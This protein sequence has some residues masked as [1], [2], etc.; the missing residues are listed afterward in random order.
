[1]DRLKDILL[2]ALLAM[3]AVTLL[4]KDKRAD[5]DNGT[6][7][8]ADTVRVTVYDTIAYLM[9]TASDSTVI[10]R[11]TARLAVADSYYSGD[12]NYSNNSGYSKADNFPNKGNN[13]E[14]NI[15]DSADVVVPITQ[16]KYEDS[17]YRAWVSGY[18]ASLDTLIFYPRTEIVTITEREKPKRWS[19]GVQ[20][21]YGMTL[22]GTP[23]FAPYF[24]VGVSY[25]LFSF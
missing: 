3:L 10:G 4:W 19:V 5:G 13:V 15:P 22:K 14:E 7:A 24:G 21:G 6:R 1:M 23:Q 9:P 11:V 12:S 17:T 25:N 18:R 8:M 20:V 16:K 2:L